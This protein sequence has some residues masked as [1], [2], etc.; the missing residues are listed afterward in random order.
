MS[1]RPLD[2]ESFSKRALLD[3]PSCA[4]IRFRPLDGESFSKLVSILLL[5][6]HFLRFRPLDG[7]SF[8][9]LTGIDSCSIDMMSKF[10]S[11]RRGIIF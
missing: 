1:F 7:E 4:G 6:Q 2:G 5:I 3:L 11:P 8:S 9:K 10:P